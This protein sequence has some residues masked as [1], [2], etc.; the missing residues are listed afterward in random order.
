MRFQLN[1]ELQRVLSNWQLYGE[2]VELTLDFIYFH[3]VGDVGNIWP[4][5]IWLI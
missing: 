4:D 5:Q 1:V 3:T 2:W